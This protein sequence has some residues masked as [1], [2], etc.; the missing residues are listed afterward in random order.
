MKS[1]IKYISNINNSIYKKELFELIKKR[2][3]SYIILNYYFF[4]YVKYI[5]E[6][7]KMNYYEIIDGNIDELIKILRNDLKGSIFT[8]CIKS[9]IDYKLYELIGLLAFK[10]YEIECYNDRVIDSYID[11]NKKYLLISTYSIPYMKQGNVDIYIDDN[12]KNIS[13]YKLLD[14]ITGINREY[15]FDLNN[16]DK[17]DCIIFINDKSFIKYR[18]IIK[19]KFKK[20]LMKCNYMELSNNRNIIYDS[21]SIMLDNNKLYIEYGN[22]NNLDDFIYDNNR[23]INIK[24][25]S[26]ISDNNLSN[27]INND[28]EIDN[29][30][31]NVTYNDL[32]NNNY[33]IGIK[34]LNKDNKK[35]NHLVDYSKFITK[36]IRLLDDEIYIQI[37]KMLNRY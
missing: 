12:N 34:G 35:I 22:N 3:N 29:I 36:K 17:Y 31:I 24:E 27:I 30:S 32:R 7:E 16:I 21:Q 33:R 37:D 23:T 14:K 28:K 9:F 4:L 8:L 20:I 2:V 26:N 25:L 13:K 18:T 10:E 19:R 5:I 15:I 11:N 6:K 1:N